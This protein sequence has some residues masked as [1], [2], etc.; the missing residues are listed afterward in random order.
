MT[1]GQRSVR[2]SQSLWK[3][4]S[5]TE[6]LNQMAEG[7]MIAG[8]GICFTHLTD[9][10]LEA[11]MPVDSRTHQPFGLLHGGASVALAES[12]GSM[13][14]WLC[15]QPGQNVVRTEISA[16]HLRGVF[17]GTV[18]GVCRSLNAGA[19]SQV[20]QIEIFDDGDRL[21]CISRLT[22]TIIG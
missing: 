12:L 8:L 4:Q 13:A 2:K 9:D 20:W 10:R 5:S 1:V 16:S 18:R 21:C 6:A 11:S 15:S 3:R 14:G 19:T 22:T 7:N 17:S